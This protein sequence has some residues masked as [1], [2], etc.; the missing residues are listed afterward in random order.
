[1][2]I[3]LFDKDRDLETL[4][5]MNYKLMQVHKAH[6]LMQFK[7][8]KGREGA[9][10][11]VEAALA[12]GHIVLIAE[13]DLGKPIGMCAIDP[14]DIPGKVQVPDIHWLYVREDYRGRG[15]GTA[16]IEAAVAKMKEEFPNAPGY[17]IGAEYW[18]EQAWK[19]YA[20][21]GFKP[22]AIRLYYQAEGATYND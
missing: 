19:L 1:M 7:F 11:E 16:L 4:C 2:K 3:R 10:E 9:D 5:D 12:N 18:N 22:Q 8:Q 14:R 17:C 6:S 15:V 13:T 21:M 20:K